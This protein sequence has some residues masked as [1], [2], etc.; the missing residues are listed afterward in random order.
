MISIAMATYNGEEFIKEQLDSILQQTYKDF[1]LIICDDCSSDNTVEILKEYELKDNRIK[2]IVNESNLGF[3]KNFEK[4]ISLCNG[5]FIAFCD[6]DDIW[7]D[8]HLEILLN[9]IGDKDLICGNAELIDKTGNKMHLT[10]Y[11]CLSN[12]NF[13]PQKEFL[14][15]NLLYG[16][17]AQGTAMMITRRIANQI[18]PIPDCVLYHD[19]WAASIATLNNG[20]SYTKKTVLLY[21]QHDSNQTVTKEYKVFSSIKKA[22]EKRKKIKEE[23]KNKIEYAT[24]LE[25]RTQNTDF[26]NSI[27][28]SKQ[29]YTSLLHNLRKGIPLFKKNYSSIYWVR[30]PSKKLYLLRFIKIFLFKI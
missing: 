10:T 21:R 28:E 5:D 12:F 26:L 2:V 22:I 11:E 15:K 20:C 18:V 24:E 17:F 16:N 23:Y 7:T 4:L 14:F 1:E 13:P 29:Y 19:W 30:N 6:Q 27:Q 3:K 9:E 8:D 25:K